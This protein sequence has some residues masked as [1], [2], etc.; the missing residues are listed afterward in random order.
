MANTIVTIK[1]QGHHGL[2]VGLVVNVVRE[3]DEKTVFITSPQVSK[4]IAKDDLNF[5]KGSKQ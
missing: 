4:A 3:V 1:R 2:P 5:I